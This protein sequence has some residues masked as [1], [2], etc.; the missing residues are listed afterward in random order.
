VAVLSIGTR[1]NPIRISLSAKD[2]MTFVVKVKNTS[3]AP[4]MA[5]VDFELPKELGFDT[6]GVSNKKNA[7]LG[8]IAPGES[9]ET[10]FEVYATHRASEKD[11]TARITAFAHYRDYNNVI[12]KATLNATIRVL[13]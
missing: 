3:D 4:Q 9:K 8:E 6:T 13:E 1:C 7:K 5:S 12:E 11:Y 2:T 10:T